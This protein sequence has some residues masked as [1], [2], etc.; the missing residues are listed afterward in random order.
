MSYQT[1]NGTAV[2]GSDY[3]AAAGALTFAPG[4]TSRTVSVAVVGDAVVEGDETFSLGLS[5]LANATA[6]DLQGSGTIVDDD[7]PSL[8]RLELSHG[9]AQ[10]AD[11]AAGP[12]P[13]Q[14]TDYYRLVQAPRASYEVVL[15]GTSGDVGP[16]V[17]LDRLGSDNVSVVQSATAVGTGASV[18]LRWENTLAAPVAN[19][20]LRVRS[21]GCTVACGP[22][23]VYRVRAYETTYTIARFNNSGGQV[24]I[25]LLQNP[26]SQA[27][28][29]H[30]H[31]WDPAGTLLHAQ[32]FTIVP[33]GVFQLSAVGVPVL[34]GRSG[35]ITVSSDARYGALAGKA[36]SLESATGFSFD[37]PM[38]AR[39]R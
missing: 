32:P 12:G 38:L 6:G 27:V 37:S 26:T 33:R 25:V 35:S 11:L 20:H 16:G 18:S 14:D 2:A 9:S 19:Q 1:A 23:D 15:D 30:V 17:L 22:D 5:A 24:T 13:S 3:T 39:P 28:S 7:A 21:A 34:Q 8:S 31:F 29:G 4:Q 36:V 10:W